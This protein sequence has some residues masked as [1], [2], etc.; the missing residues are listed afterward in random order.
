MFFRENYK[1]YNS[2]EKCRNTHDTFRINCGT[3][4]VFFPFYKFFGHELF[5]Y[6]VIL[7]VNPVFPFIV[8]HHERKKNW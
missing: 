1:L 4:N 8:H 3:V 6:S 5:K 2:I 7:I